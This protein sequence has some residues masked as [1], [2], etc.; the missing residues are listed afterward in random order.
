MG[1]RL[2]SAAMYGKGWMSLT[3]WPLKE[4][5]EGVEHAMVPRS[6]TVGNCS[7]GEW[8]DS[9]R[10]LKKKLDTGKNTYL[11]HAHV[12]RLDEV[13]MWCGAE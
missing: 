12:H 11:T 9:L 8:I 5:M 13:G 6:T 10:A 7:L 3:Q 2:I 4:S 1:Y